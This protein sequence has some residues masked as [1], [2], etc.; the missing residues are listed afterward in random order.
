MADGG[1]FDW[2][3]REATEEGPGLTLQ[4]ALQRGDVAAVCAQACAP[5]QPVDTTPWTRS[6]T[7]LTDPLTVFEHRLR[8]LC[9]SRSIRLICATP[10]TAPTGKSRIYAWR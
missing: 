1:G 9:G 5:P 7:S 8:C 2:T 3:A 4:G 6:R 10:A